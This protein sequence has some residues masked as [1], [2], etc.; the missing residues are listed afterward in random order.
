MKTDTEDKTAYFEAMHLSQECK[1]FFESSIGKYILARA[2]LES[3]HYLDFLKNTIVNEDN[4]NIVRDAQLKHKTI[5]LAI[6]WMRDAIIAGELAE[7]KLR[8]DDFNPEMEAN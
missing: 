4:I 6:D 2:D 7:F 3:N 1:K 5:N 8:E